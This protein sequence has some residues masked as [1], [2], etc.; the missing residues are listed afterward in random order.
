MKYRIAPSLLSADF[1]NLAGEIAQIDGYADWLHLDVMDGH[2]VPNLTFGMPLI[3]AIRPLTQMV[4]DCHIMTSNPLEYLERFAEAGADLVSVHVEA[5]IDP[6]EHLREAHQL[7]IRPGLAISPDTEF[8]TVEPFLEGMELIVV[9]SVY[10][11]FGGQAFM[12]KVLS[13]VE[14]VRKWV[15]GHSVNTDIEVDGGVGVE[16]IRLARDAGANVFVAGTSVFKAPV[17][18]E[19]IMALRDMVEEK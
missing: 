1:G 5:G 6:S 15:E 7:G 18:S 12:P 4:F 3:A 13:K 16:N 17:P 10:P 9:M 19:A 14:A 2:F 11:G 8:E